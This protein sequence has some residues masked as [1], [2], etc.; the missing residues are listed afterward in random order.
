MLI[1]KKQLLVVAVIGALLFIGLGQHYMWGQ[2]AAKNVAAKPL[3]L[4][5]TV[6]TQRADLPIKFTAQ[7]HLVA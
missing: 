6:I 1:R 4:V 2:P 3:P 5:T 7:G